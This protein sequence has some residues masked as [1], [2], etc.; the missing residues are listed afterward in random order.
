[1]GVEREKRL[2]EGE[3]GGGGRSHDKSMKEHVPVE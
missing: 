3:G 2:A 1:M